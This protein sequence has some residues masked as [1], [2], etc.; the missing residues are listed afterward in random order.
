MNSSGVGQ[1]SSN[2]KT[3]TIDKQVDAIH[4]D[5]R[6]VTVQKIAKST[7]I[8]AGSV[9][10]MVIDILGMSKLSARWVPRMLVTE[11]KLIGFWDT[12]YPFSVLSRLWSRINDSKQ[13]V[14]ALWFFTYQ[15]IQASGVCWQG[16]DL[17]VLGLYGCYHDILFGKE[18]DYKWSILCVI[19]AKVKGSNQDGTQKKTVSS[20]MR[21]STWHEWQW[22][23]QLWIW[24]IDPCPLLTHLTWHCL[25]STCFLNCMDTILEAMIKLSIL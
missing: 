6:Q 12:L 16:D 7:Y 15:N 1:Q 18:S 4:L 2:V 14:E 13:T 21:L 22:S 25:A 3:S 9:H 20:T 23:G 11:H 10:T 24:I 19:I 17:C 8:S 5:C